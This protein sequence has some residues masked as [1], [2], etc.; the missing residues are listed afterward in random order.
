[1]SPGNGGGISRRLVLQLAA[2]SLALPGFAGAAPGLAADAGSAA[3]LQAYRRMRYSAGTDVA[4]W[5][6]RATKYGLVDQQL[7]PL[8]AME[9]GNFARTRSTGPDSFAA[10]ALEMVFFTD[11]ASNERVEAFTNPYTGERIER[12]DSLVGPTTIE[13]TL[14]GPK[15]PAVLPGV[16]FDVKPALGLFAVEG[17]DVWLRDDNSTTVT[18]AGSGAVQFVVSDWATYHC[19][20]AALGDVALD[21]VP[22]DV[23]FNSVSSWLRWMNMGAR[24]G[25]MLSRGSGRKYARLEDMP[26]SFLKILRNRYPELAKDP[27]GALARE[28]FSFAP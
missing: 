3:L 8:F 27:A 26:G 20:A 24:P 18:E 9:I 28:P 21:S 11:P 10:T 13:Y 5:W 15:Y 2:G 17:E 1:M 12:P 14:D 22:C 4:F 23:A 6:M 25:S 19:T 16:N 7:T